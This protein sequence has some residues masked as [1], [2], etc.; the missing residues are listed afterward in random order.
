MLGHIL[1]TAVNAVMP[2]IL[3]IGV[4]Y[5]LKRIGMMNENFVKTGRNLV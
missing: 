2:I 4:G 3:L 5:T 1:L